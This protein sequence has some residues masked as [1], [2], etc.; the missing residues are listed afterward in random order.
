MCGVGI[1]VVGVAR[2]ARLLDLYGDRLAARW[3]A[4][5]EVAECESDPCPAVAYACRFAAK[6]A[7]WKA[8]AVSWDG[9]LPWRWIVVGTAT[10]TPEVEL[11]GR[12]AGAA[13]LAG[14]TSVSVDWSSSGDL[15]TAVAFAYTA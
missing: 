4:A 8:L 5:S 3:F 15:A 7:V 13:Q 1:D 9:S 12:V 11:R 10:G 6:E 2:L 14:V